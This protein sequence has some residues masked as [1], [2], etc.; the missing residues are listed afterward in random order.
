MNKNKTIILSPN[1]KLIG[2]IKYKVYR[3][4]YFRYKENKRYPIENTYEIHLRV[5]KHNERGVSIEAFYP[6]GIL[7]FLTSF[8]PFSPFIGKEHRYGNP[9]GDSFKY[10]V[11][12]K[13][14]IKKIKNS[15]KI[16][17][18]IPSIIDEILKTKSSKEDKKLLIDT[19]D[20]IK[21][22][23]DREKYFI[24]DLEIIHQYYG[25]KFPTK[26]EC[27]LTA[28]IK[29]NI[30]KKLQKLTDKEFKFLS[31]FN[32]NIGGLCL[33]KA[34][35]DDKEINIDSISGV[36]LLSVDEEDWH[37]FKEIR[38]R[39]LNN[40]FDIDNYNNITLHQKNYK[41]DYRDKT[42]KYY[43]HTRRTV[44][45]KMEKTTFTT[46]ERIE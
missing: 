46:I 21:K 11:N 5:T 37:D 34:K 40:S 7:Y 13:G 24:R 31:N 12:R 28:G 19:L 38:E 3:V 9:S 44:N 27:D 30:D 42:L 36:N 2:V 39:F 32:L 43:S 15:N 4:D 18:Y 45:T 6:Q 33:L 26:V 22:R 25:Y 16:K 23:K 8:Q 20:F 14:Q 29:E 10:L 17:S 1:W 35:G 41:F